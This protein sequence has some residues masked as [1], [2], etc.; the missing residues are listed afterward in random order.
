ME[1][2]FIN[3][4]EGGRYLENET[5]IKLYRKLLISPIFENEKAL[6]VWIWC[7]LKATHTEREQLV[8]KKIIHLEVGQFVFGRNKASEELKM[9]ESSVYGYIKLL[10]KLKMIS[11]KSNNKFSVVSI[12]KW[13]DYQE[14]KIIF[15]NKKTTKK[16]QMNTN[17]NVKNIYLYLLNKY[18]RENRK[19]FNEYMKK[20][21]ELRNDP[22][23]ELLT[24][25]EQNKISAEI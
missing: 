2:L 20:M 24:S 13:E 19:D 3:I 10:E 14:K 7:L 12:E 9:S 25:V 11:V 8:G 4:K 18:K 5:W 6:K 23:Y 22:D 17:K 16:Q 1:K 21:R 15:D